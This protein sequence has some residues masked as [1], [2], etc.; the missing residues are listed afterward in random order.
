MLDTFEVPKLKGSL[1][2]EL[3]AIRL[4]AIIVEKGL[5]AYITHNSATIDNTLDEN[6]LKATTSMKLSLEDGP[7]LQTGFISN[8]Y[9]LSTTLGNLYKARG[10]SSE[11]LLCK[12]LINITL[13]S[14]KGNLEEHMD[15]FK[16]IINNLEFRGISLPGR[17]VVNI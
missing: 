2:Y 4:E 12:G 9:T 16:R 17:F 15:S 8:S 11:F 3:W 7:L 14:W 5:L 6:A 1:N 13:N 10:F